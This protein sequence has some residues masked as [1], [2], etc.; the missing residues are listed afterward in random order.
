MKPK[1]EQHILQVPARN[2][3]FQGREETLRRMHEH[4]KPQSVDKLRYC[5]LYGLGGI[6]K[7]QIAIEY[8]YRFKHLYTNIFWI[9]ASNESQLAESYSSVA[10]MIGHGSSKENANLRSDAQIA[11]HWLSS[12]GKT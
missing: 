10:R 6:G 8:I 1:T 4:L 9:R 3:L 2:D 5:V 7:T 11:R 12:T